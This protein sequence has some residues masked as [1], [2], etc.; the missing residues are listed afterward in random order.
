MLGFDLFE[1][2]TLPQ[3]LKKA[4]HRR[5]LFRLPQDESLIKPNGLPI[6]EGVLE[7]VE[8]LKIPK[9]DVIIGGNIGKK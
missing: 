2:G 8:R 4:I 1:I 5:G 3:N 9:S 7:A 6:M